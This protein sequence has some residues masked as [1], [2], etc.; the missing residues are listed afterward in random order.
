[1]KKALAIL[2]VLALVASAATAEITF[3][4]WGRG[5]FVPVQNS[6]LENVDSITTINKTWEGKN[7]T[8]GLALTSDPRVGFTVAGN[9][10]NV[11]FQVDIYADGDIARGDQ[12]K[13]WVK[14][15]DMVTMQ[16]GKFFDDTL[17]GNTAFGSFNWLRAYGG[18]EGEDITFTRIASGDHDKNWN[19]GQGFEVAVKPNEAL[20]VAL[21]LTGLES[22]VKTE[23]ITDGMQIAAG[24]TIDGIGQ[25]RAQY[26]SEYLTDPDDA[27]KIIADGTVEVAF[28]LTAVENLY[29]DFG[30]R[31]FTEKKGKNANEAKTLSAYA[32]YKVDAATIHALAI[33]NMNATAD[34]KASMN[35]A[36]GVDYALD[37][38]IGVEADVRY[39]NKEW[40]KQG[41][42]K[43][44]TSF[45]AG[46]KKGYSNGLMG[47]GFEVISA[48]KTGYAIPVR[49][50]YSF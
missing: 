48:E 25:I 42:A 40:D 15:M 37:G 8:S 39:Y 27:T 21:A 50:E 1:M 14:P 41:D 13:I 33:Y 24:Y 44:A 29:A 32:N 38:G 30:F 11:G 16:M 20:F 35:I 3:G 45:F 18:G 49:F 26:F 34:D 36:A 22:G 6:G 43:A 47:A 4:A 17:R 31:M 2:M 10:D 5:I 12:A 9:S 7:D 19:S 46:V 28:K 23:D